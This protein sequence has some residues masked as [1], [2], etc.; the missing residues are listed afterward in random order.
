[1]FYLVF[2]DPKT[3]VSTEITCKEEKDCVITYRHPNKHNDYNYKVNSISPA[4]FAAGS[5][6]NVVLDMR[7]HDNDAK[8]WSTLYDARIGRY[9]CGPISA[10]SDY[11]FRGVQAIFNCYTGNYDSEEISN[12]M[13][14]SSYGH[15]AKY[16]LFRKFHLTDDPTDAR[17]DI[18]F[19]F[20]SFANIENINFHTGSELGG[21]MLVIKGKGFN[22]DTVKVYIG[23][24][25]ETDGNNLC[26]VKEATTDTIICKTSNLSNQFL[27]DV[28][29]TPYG[30]RLKIAKFTSNPGFNRLMPNKVNYS[31]EQTLLELTGEYNDY[32]ASYFYANGK[33]CAK[34][35]GYY[36]FHAFAD[37]H[38]FLGFKKTDDNLEPD[39]VDNLNNSYD[40]IIEIKSW[41][42]YNDYFSNN[43]SS[44]FMFFKQGECKDMVLTQLNGGG[45][46]FYKVALEIC[47]K[48]LLNGE[49]PSQQDQTNDINLC[50]DTSKPSVSVTTKTRR[51]LD[52]TTD[53]AD[54]PIP[55][56]QFQAVKMIVRRRQYVRLTYSLTVPVNKKFR[57]RCSD[58]KTVSF[59]DSSLDSKSSAWDV[60]S[61]L[62]SLM[63]YNTIV[64]KLPINKSGKVIKKEV[65]S[66]I[67]EYSLYDS[68]ELYYYNPIDNYK[69]TNLNKYYG[70]Y[71]NTDTE[72]THYEYL[73]TITDEPKDDNNKLWEEKLSSCVCEYGEIDKES[74]DNE[75]SN[76]CSIKK[77]QE[78]EEGLLGS[79]KLKV[80]SGKDSVETKEIPYNANFDHIEHVLDEIS[81]L[82][83]K[84]TVVQSHIEKSD[85][86]VLHI[87]FA[88]DK[89]V[90]IEDIS[91]G[92][93]CEG[94]CRIDFK[95]VIRFN[96]NLFFTSVP[97]DFLKMP[98]YKKKLTLEEKDQDSYQLIPQILVKNTDFF[99]NEIVSACNYGVCNYVPFDKT[100][101]PVLI[102]YEINNGIHI[103]TFSKPFEITEGIEIS[104]VLYIGYASC[105]LLLQK[106]NVYTCNNLHNKVAGIYTP[107]VSTQFGYI[108]VDNSSVKDISYD[109]TISSY[110]SLNNKI[111]KTGGSKI[112]I[113]GQNFPSLKV[114]ELKDIPDNFVTVG[115][116]NCLI[117]SITF[118]E[119]V[120]YNTAILDE[121]NTDKIVINFNSKTAEAAELITW[122]NESEKIYIF[123]PK[124]LNYATGVKQLVRLSFKTS[125]NGQDYKDINLNQFD[126]D[127]SEVTL[128]HTTIN[129][130]SIPIGIVA[131]NLSNS[132]DLAYPGGLNGVYN[133]VIRLV[134]IKDSNTDT[135]LDTPETITVDNKKFTISLP[136]ILSIFPKEGTPQ[137]GTVITL[138]GR[139]F[140]VDN[141][142]QHIYIGKKRCK[143]YT[144]TP[145]KITCVTKGLQQEELNLMDKKLDISLDQYIQYS[146]LC[147]DPEG[148]Y[149][150]YKQSLF[151][152]IN[153]LLK[154][155]YN[156]NNEVIKEYETRIICD[157]CYYKITGVNLDKANNNKNQSDLHLYDKSYYEMDNISEDN[158]KSC[159]SRNNCKY[160][161][162]YK[163]RIAEL[164]V[165]EVAEDGRYIIFESRYITKYDLYNFFIQFLN[166]VVLF[167]YNDLEIDLNII[168]DRSNVLYNSIFTSLDPELIDIYPKK[169][170][171]NGGIYKFTINYLEEEDVPYKNY[172]NILNNKCYI[173]D[174]KLIVDENS[175]Y[176]YEC[177]LTID[178]NLLNNETSSPLAISY[179]NKVFE[180]KD[181]NK[182]PIILSLDS[183]MEFSVSKVTYESEDI[184]LLDDL[185][186]TT[187]DLSNEFTLRFTILNTY[188]PKDYKINILL[189]YENLIELLNK[190]TNEDNT[191]SKNTTTTFLFVINGLPL[192]ENTI[193]LHI[194]GKGF[195]LFSNNLNNFKL[196]NNNIYAKNSEDTYCIFKG[197]CHNIITGLNLNNQ[198][199]DLSNINKNIDISNNYIF[200]NEVYVCNIKGKIQSITSTTIEYEAPEIVMYKDE[201]SKNS[202]YDDIDLMHSDYKEM[203]DISL[204]KFG[205]NDEI[206]VLQDDNIESYL[207]TESIDKSFIKYKIKDELINKHFRFK[208]KMAKIYPSMLSNPGDFVNANIKAKTLDLNDD[209]SNAKEYDIYNVKSNLEA[210]WE[211]LEIEKNFSEL[212]LTELTL[213]PNKNKV[214]LSEFR[215]FGSVV[216]ISN[217]STSDLLQK[218]QCP[219]SIS[220]LIDNKKEFNILKNSIFY[221]L[222]NSLVLEKLNEKSSN[223]VYGTA[224][225]GTELVFELSNSD[226]NADTTYD[227]TYTN[228]IVN[229]HGV[230]STIK[231]VNNES[232]NK[233]LII[234]ETPQK[235][236]VEYDINKPITIKIKKLGYATIDYS[237]FDFKYRDKWS[238]RNTWGGEF[239][240][241]NGETVFIKNADIILDVENITLNG[242]FIDNGS[243]FVEDNADYN[244]NTKYLVITGGRLQIGT[245]DN[246][247]EKHKFTLTLEGTQDDNALPLF[248]NKVL[249]IYEGEMDIHGKIRK[250]VWTQ[251]SKD[252]LKGDK[253]IT[254][255]EEVDWQIGEFI[256]IAST[257]YSPSHCEEREISEIDNS[258]SKFPVIKFKTALKYNHNGTIDTRTSISGV[259]DSIDMRAE[260]GLLTRN[261][262]I[263]GDK[264]SENS[265]Y[266][267]HM[268]TTASKK[269]GIRTGILRMSYVELY[270]GGQAFQLGTYPI[271][272]HMLG[273]AKQSFIKGISIH[274]AFNRGITLHAVN[275]LTID[276]NVLYNVKGHSIFVEDSVEKFNKVTNNLVI[277]TK[278]SL[279]LLNVD[280]HPASFWITHPTNYY[281]GNHA[282]GSETYGFWMEFP[283]KPTGLHMGIEACPDQEPLGSFKNNVAHSNGLYGL[284]IFPYYHPVSEPCNASSEPVKATFENLTVYANGERGFI[285]EEIGFLEFHGFKGADNKE[286]N[287]E[288]SQSVGFISNFI[289]TSPK[290]INAFVIGH[291][292]SVN[293]SDNN[294]K[295]HSAV[296]INLPRTDNFVLE[297]A[298]FYS[299]GKEGD[300]LLSTCSRC[301]VS[302]PSSDSGARTSFT[303]YLRY[304]ETVNNKVYYRLP[305]RAIIADIDGS[306]VNKIINQKLKSYSEYDT[307][308]IIPQYFVTKYAKHLDKD[309]NSCSPCVKDEN[310]GK[311]GVYCSNT[312]KQQLRRVAFF[313][314]NSNKQYQMNIRAYNE[315]TIQINDVEEMN[316]D[317]YDSK[318]NEDKKLEESQVKT[319]TNKTS[320]YPFKKVRDPAGWAIPIVTGCKYL[321]SFGTEQREINT[322]NY[323][324]SNLY[325]TNDAPTVFAFKY[326]NNYFDFANFVKG[327]I[328]K[329]ISSVQNISL[330]N[331][332]QAD[333]TKTE[334]SYGSGFHDQ[335]NKAFY[336]VVDGKSVTDNNTNVHMSIKSYTCPDRQPTCIQKK[337]IGDIVQKRW[338]DSSSWPLNKI[339]EDNEDVTIEAEWDMLLDIS[340]PKLKNLIINGRLYADTS[341]EIN[342]YAN[343]ILISDTGN[344]EYGTEENPVKSKSKIVLTGDKTVG[345]IN[346]SQKLKTTPKS[347]IN[348]NKLS[349]YGKDKAPYTSRLLSNIEK[350]KTTKIF[351]DKNLLW[352]ENDEIVITTTNQF[353]K[354]TDRVS[355]KR[356][357]KT[358]GELVVNEL[359]KYNHIGF[360]KEEIPVINDNPLDGKVNLDER[361]IVAMISRT[362]SIEGDKENASEIGC[363]IITSTI[364]FK[365]FIGNGKTII[366][367][368]EINNC[369]QQETDF[370]SVK[371]EFNGEKESN[372]LLINKSVLEGVSFK[373]NNFIPVL[374]SE[375][376]DIILKDIIA[377][378]PIAVGLDIHSGSSYIEVDNYLVINQE[379]KPDIIKIESMKKLDNNACFM[380]CKNSEC[381]NIILKNTVCAGAESFGYVIGANKCVNSSKENDTNSDDSNE[382]INSHSLYKTAFACELGGVLVTDSRGEN[383]LTSSHFIV[384]NNRYLGYSN[385]PV[386]NDILTVSN[387]LSAN[388]EYG[389]GI[390]SGSSNN[391]CTKKLENSVIIGKTDKSNCLDI[392]GHQAGIVMSMTTSKTA[393]KFPI[394]ESKIP[395]FVGSNDSNWSSYFIT[396]N[397]NLINWEDQCNYDSYA[398]RSNSNSTD[399]QSH[400]FMDNIYAERVI[401]DN[402]FYIDDPKENSANIGC[403]FIPCTGTK[404]LS[405]KIGKFREWKKELTNEDIPKF[406]DK[407]LNPLNCDKKGSI[408]FTPYDMRGDLGY[409]HQK[410]RPSISINKEELQNKFKTYFIPSNSSLKY[411]KDYKS[412]IKL[413][414]NGWIIPKLD[415]NKSNYLENCFSVNS[416]NAISCL[417]TSNKNK[418]FAILTFES[419]VYETV[420]KDGSSNKVL[421][422]NIKEAISPVNITNEYR[423]YSNSLNSYFDHGCNFGYPRLERTPRYHAVIETVEKSNE[424]SVYL[425]KPKGTTPGISI[426]EL[427]AG[428]PNQ[429]P[430]SAYV[431]IDYKKKRKMK[432]LKNDKEINDNCDYHND[433]C[434][435]KKTK[436]T[437]RFLDFFIKSNNNCVCTIVEVS[438]IDLSFNVVDVSID[439]IYNSK[440]TSL[441]AS[442]TTSLGI[443]D[444]SRVRITNIVKGSAN[445]NSS[446]SSNNSLRFLQTGTMIEIE[447]LQSNP[448]DILKR[449]KQ[450]EVEYDYSIPPS[451]NPSSI[452]PNA[453]NNQN[454]DI[455]SLNDLQTR[456]IDKLKSGDIAMPFKVENVS[457]TQTKPPSTREVENPDLIIEDA[458]N[459][460][461]VV[462]TVP[463][464]IL[465]DNSNSSSEINSS[466]SSNLNNNSSEGVWYWYIIL[467][468]CIIVTTVIT[469]VL[470][471]VCI[472]KN[473]SISNIN[474][475][476][477]SP[478]KK[479]NSQNI[480]GNYNFDKDA[481]SL[482]LR[483]KDNKK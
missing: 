157:E 14:Q 253:Q 368:A 427:V 353:R 366:K 200:T 288:V 237:K 25:K 462:I 472:K 166:G 107:K 146:A 357:D 218:I 248:G 82:T 460:N 178:E 370:S 387:I 421:V 378:N 259:V 267:F 440:L 79:M 15:A 244:I 194:L 167:N 89:N 57:L 238:S 388:N 130:Y 112:I 469:V 340:T 465:N 333:N 77:T 454:E 52:S 100:Y 468:S 319:P 310:L 59:P 43:N 348:I 439:D 317:V 30:L 45:P 323:Q 329:E 229:I 12:F 46:G 198:F 202:N 16:S 86:R 191:D 117:K 268:L 78:S 169:I 116:S 62:N 447:I 444:M 264:Y 53:L 418:E 257:D 171:K 145:N 140:M 398:L 399:S 410:D 135:I 144:A 22:P 260:V 276:N 408:C 435:L 137:G 471:F 292:N 72:H 136:I 429:N 426:W 467:I 294:N 284:R 211:I 175:K 312:S 384:Y 349:I 247:F 407:W 212:L 347:L 197:G 476:I 274:K 351:V 192:G 213:Y 375:S 60:R 71:D 314:L 204:H 105:E 450:E 106:E 414:D 322:L 381:D 35:T 379:N 76:K 230:K 39:F 337:E 49:V 97:A 321:I 396:D 361:A 373:D 311:N 196:T 73:I 98:V 180:A 149:F 70:N 295:N 63:N 85:Y 280:F 24:F 250:P 33:F 293:F 232:S 18:P 291:S 217:M 99:G 132:F 17:L 404:T 224:A 263:Q 155:E 119:I 129:D 330:F 306:L 208:L 455:E 205:N 405:I 437:E 101:T 374:I 433:C 406:N 364:D 104:P 6:L 10:D 272:F 61:F 11:K 170:N 281:E 277:H 243:L 231:S 31:E 143:I 114:V 148:C 300:A 386:A 152:K 165:K 90:Q 219:V 56:K 417:S 188:L 382:I 442:I 464:P 42:R 242:L 201:L 75:F 131:T 363:S 287:L 275:Y 182:N 55:N 459:Q 189:N 461:P 252:A 225:G 438:T 422:R 383:C 309:N 159:K 456:L 223:T 446:S 183:S 360:S 356:Y 2:E 328:N 477:D 181:S 108:S 29:D 147:N 151:A 335:T 126:L 177:I 246:R 400:T 355:I 304:D 424:N 409:L 38:L 28:I 58:N 474:S 190:E 255:K 392:P 393:V 124:E 36:R 203:F 32:E 397:I 354:E 23:T 479:K 158:L 210:Q 428:Y 195:A 88:N 109:I 111:F 92:L 305:Y 193:M 395:L 125:V 315:N 134:R 327:D 142:D 445:N 233:I 4:Y 434:C 110:S 283:H 154:L 228:Y 425:I 84:V 326:Y 448:L 83:N 320:I 402:L 102:N 44:E 66:N 179:Y 394:K 430:Q 359:L 431:R 318:S 163:H 1:M 415:E 475:Y 338:S 221:N 95:D 258:N 185:S 262:K 121:N 324:R 436:K 371:F 308:N 480:E 7:Y 214:K 299:F 65:S 265:E 249:G 278:K 156:D 313:D 432:I 91:R 391:H 50:K 403:G 122:N 372:H 271:H 350:D 473:R 94:K 412:F 289:L 226:N 389:I 419:K 377:Y 207:T 216:N 266:G 483:D 209:I 69:L 128:Y 290:I 385:Y 352:E 222:E 21:Q 81:F 457:I 235:S 141:F 68:S 67:S 339:P 273:N 376:F 478:A 341:K 451:E 47:E 239:V 133:L 51:R 390:N 413:S 9:L 199:T 138:T 297:D 307:N 449:N 286:T 482:N 8:Q 301:E 120:C 139:N 127:Q 215:I 401:G 423:G 26:K 254:L 420:E 240:P 20:K 150:I 334:V 416:W 173:L 64:K 463:D 160:I 380:I 19:Y 367:H 411:N 358:T 441:L 344:L 54:I 269:N 343:N 34:Y 40:T 176:E 220:Y 270:R 161:D 187:R 251:I 118:T 466:N 481:Q 296:G 302:D 325:S 13:I 162:T 206:S 453:I 470:Y 245:E 186:N 331:E 172:L 3:Y 316:G 365:G 346:V 256:V 458:N 261:I 113:N 227:E 103:V 303:N 342:I 332:Y 168:F 41:T 336:F 115:G 236:K 5:K 234:V 37:D 285:T 80:T 153:G 345:N 96:K 184:N 362:V 369:G 279:S 443:T 452:D 48:Q 87:Y 241:K 123:S 93:L 174:K 74:T 164:Y 298:R 27:K 282:A